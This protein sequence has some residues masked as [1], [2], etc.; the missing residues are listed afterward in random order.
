MVEEEKMDA[1]TLAF[2]RKIMRTLFLGFAWMMAM[3]ILGIFMQ[4]GYVASGWGWW[5]VFFYILL[6]AS[7]YL[8]LKHY[9][10]LWYGTNANK[11]IK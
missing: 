6:T 9:Y 2:L 7:L 4:G 10:S 5:N 1:A 11:P 3:V 8:L